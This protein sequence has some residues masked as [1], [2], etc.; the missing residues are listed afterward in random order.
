MAELI[1]SLNPFHSCDNIIEAGCQDRF[2]D[3]CRNLVGGQ[4]VE[5]AALDEFDDLINNYICRPF[6]FGLQKF[7]GVVDNFFK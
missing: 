1:Q 3:T 2:N 4:T 7:Q 6:D 5:K